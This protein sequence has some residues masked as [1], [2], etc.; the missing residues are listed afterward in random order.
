MHRGMRLYL[1][2][3]GLHQPAEGIYYVVAANGVFLVNRTSLFA[4]VTPARS[5]PGLQPCEPSLQLF[6]PRVPAR[7]MDEL[8]GFFQAVYRRWDGEAVAFLFYAP[9]R[10]TFRVAV[11]PQT[12][13]RYR[14]FGHWYT[15]RRVTYA[16]L[17]R[18]D[19]FIKL[20]DAHS[21]PEMPAFVSSTD[22]RDDQQDGLRIVLGNLHRPRPD[23]HVS[24]VAHATRFPLRPEDVLEDFAAPIPPPAAWLDMI[25]CH[26]EDGHR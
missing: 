5:L 14:S 16:T 20:G 13:V 15:E 4:S 10:R 26:H 22:D 2:T 12:L 3:P 25:T 23:V 19:G 9:A 18:P 6:I 1:N 8:W 17:P 11:P 7:V 24:F 21:H